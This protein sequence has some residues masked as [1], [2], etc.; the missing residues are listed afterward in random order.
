MVTCR[1][2]GKKIR[3]AKDYFKA[4]DHLLTFQNI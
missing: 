3:K 4:K 1:E 2:K